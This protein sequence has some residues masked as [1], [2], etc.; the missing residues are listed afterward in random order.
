MCEQTEV[1]YLEGDVVWVKLGACWWPGRVRDVDK[2]PDDILESFRKK[3]IAAVQFF[4]EDKYEY[5]KNLDQICRYNCRRKTDFIKK[6]LDMYRAKQREGSSFMDKFPND[7]SMAEQLTGGNP[8]IVTDNAF[9]PEEK[10]S[11]R[12]IFGSEKK[13]DKKGKMGSSSP[14]KGSPSWRSKIA[15]PSTPK[16][17][18][19]SP[20][21]PITHPRIIRM[22]KGEEE[23]HDV[24]IRQQPLTPQREPSPQ[25]EPYKCYKCDFTSKRLNV[26]ILHSKSHSGD[27]ATNGQ[28]P[29]HIRSKS[30]TILSTPHRGRGRPRGSHSG[31]I[32]RTPKNSPKVVP[33]NSSDTME[34]NSPKGTSALDVN[35]EDNTVKDVVT[36][37]EKKGLKTPIFGKRKNAKASGDKGTKKKKSSEDFR[38]KLLAEWEDEDQEEEEKEM[39]ILKRELSKSEALSSPPPERSSE[40]TNYSTNKVSSSSNVKPKEIS[41]F[42]FDEQADSLLDHE[43]E[44]RAKKF[45]EARKFPRR[46]DDKV[47]LEKRNEVSADVPKLKEISPL[48]TAP[49]TES[50]DYDN[51][52]KKDL[53]TEFENLMAETELPSLPAVPTIKIKEQQREVITSPELED[54][55]NEKSETIVHDEMG[56]D[57]SLPHLKDTDDVEPPSNTT[58]QHPPETSIQFSQDST[59]EITAE[60]QTELAAEIP[61][62]TP[63]ESNDNVPIESQMEMSVDH[64]IDLLPSA[65]EEQSTT[66]SVEL[67]LQLPSEVP[68]ET[69]VTTEP[70]VDISSEFTQSTP[71]NVAET[72]SVNESHHPPPPEMPV[73][74]CIQEPAQ[75]PLIPESTQISPEQPPAQ[76]AV[77]EEQTNMTLPQETAQIS[78]MHDTTPI[79][80]S[81][82]PVQLSVGQ[83]PVQMSLDEMDLDINSMPVVMG[84]TL[85]TEDSTTK[86]AIN[87]I[88]PANSVAI[89]LPPPVV[90][91]KPTIQPVMRLTSTA[92][93]TP[94][95]SSTVTL[96]VTPTLEL[97]TEAST[98]VV[99]SSAQT[100]TA[101]S[102]PKIVKQVVK[103]VKIHPGPSG[104]LRTSD[105]SIIAPKGATTGSRYVVIQHASGKQTIYATSSAKSGQQCVTVKTGASQ[106]QGSTQTVGKKLVIVKSPQGG[107][108]SPE[109]LSSLQ[110]GKLV[111]QRIITSQGTILK[112]M[113]RSTPKVMH[114][115]PQQMKALTGG[116]QV[117][118]TKLTMQSTP[119][120]VVLPT[121]QKMVGQGQSVKLVTTA[122]SAKS[123]PNTILIQTT[124]GTSVGGAIV[125]RAVSGSVAGVTTSVAKLSTVPQT[126]MR[127]VSGSPRSKIVAT[128]SPS[129]TSV[130]RVVVSTAG[131]GSVLQG[132][133]QQRVLAARS[134]VQP[135]M[136]VQK[137][138]GTSTVRV[139]NVGAIAGVQPQVAQVQ[140]VKKVQGALPRTQVLQK[141]KQGQVVQKVVT[142][143]QPATATTIKPTSSTEAAQ[144]IALPSLQPLQ[145][146]ISGAPNVQQNLQVNTLVLSS[147]PTVINQNVSTSQSASLP[148]ATSAPLLS[149]EHIA[150]VI[151][152]TGSEQL[153]DG[154]TPTYVLVTIDDQ[155]AIQPYDSSGLVTSYDGSS[156]SS[157]SNTRTLYIDPS[158]LGTSGELDNIFL[159]I[160]NTGTA[161]SGTLL[162][163]GQANTVASGNIATTQHSQAVF[164]I[165]DSQP[166]TPAGSQDIL[167]AALANTDVFQTDGSMSDSLTVVNSSQS[168]SGSVMTSRLLESSSLLPSSTSTTL[169]QTT[170]L[171]PSLSATAMPPANPAGVLETSLTLNQPIMTPLEVPSSVTNLQQPAPPIPTSLE[172]PLTITQPVLSMPATSPYSTLPQQ[173]SLQAPETD[174]VESPIS[175]SSVSQ[176]A[177]HPVLSSRPTLQP[178]MPLLSEDVSDSQTT[179]T[180]EANTDAEILDHQP[181]SSFSTAQT[182][183]EQDSEGMAASNT[184]SSTEQLVLP[185]YAQVPEVSSHATEEHE[186]PNDALNYDTS[187]GNQQ[188]TNQDLS[189]SYHEVPESTSEVSASEAQGTPEIGETQSASEQTVSTSYARSLQ[190]SVPKERTEVIDSSNPPTNEPP[191]PNYSVENSSEALAMKDMTSAQETSHTDEVCV[192]YEQVESTSQLRDGLGEA[193]TEVTQTLPSESSTLH[194]YAPAPESTSNVSGEVLEGNS[195]GTFSLPSYSQTPE[196]TCEL[197]EEKEVIPN[198]SASGNYSQVPESTS[199]MSETRVVGDSPMD[200]LDSSQHSLDSSVLTPYQVPESSSEASVVSYE[201]AHGASGVTPPTSNQTGYTS[202]SQVPESTSQ[203]HEVLSFS[204]SSTE[205]S[206]CAV[207]LAQSMPLLLDSGPGTKRHVEGEGTDAND[208]E[209]SKRVK[210][211]ESERRKDQVCPSSCPLPTPDSLSLQKDE[212]CIASDDDDDLPTP[213]FPQPACNKKKFDRDD[214]VWMKINKLY[215]PGVV[216]RGFKKRQLAH[217]KFIN[218]PFQAAT[219]CKR[220]QD[221]IDF[222]DNSRNQQLLEEGREHDPTIEEA[223]DKIKDFWF[224]N[225]KTGGT[226]SAAK[227]FS[228]NVDDGTFESCNGLNFENNASDGN[229]MSPELDLHLD[230]S[231]S[232]KEIENGKSISSHQIDGEAKL[233]LDVIESP[234]C[235]EHLQQVFSGFTESWRHSL[236]MTKSCAKQQSLFLNSGLGPFSYKTGMKMITCLDKYFME[237]DEFNTIARYGSRK[238]YLFHVLVP[239]ALVYA[240][241]K[242]HDL[243]LE[244]AEQ[245]F[246][247]LSSEVI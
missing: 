114:V 121:V 40:G 148:V 138:R 91:E 103:S 169:H 240:I 206:D 237:I 186:A 46:L 2:L 223:F 195:S 28:E 117:G 102:A 107:P 130:Q 98:S 185:S 50:E 23:Q 211:D 157:E 220:F 30:A 115:T 76:L 212:G 144:S 101:N 88:V 13:P 61:G 204:D 145:S 1:H 90:P 7:V 178:S 41:C 242:V 15:S 36:T 54:V 120:K 247:D 94:S 122:T 112:Q 133:A 125:T 230:L 56:D 233:L 167:A 190:D 147:A 158:S 180:T 95:A 225:Y 201:D 123:K 171:L 24:R 196:S 93:S 66:Q 96:N 5:V 35:A 209:H 108:V 168:T 183:T 181:G 149:H 214:I 218:K 162:N 217:V 192:P 4:N 236:F 113:G 83:E 55:K 234:V 159:A 141:G 179:V 53:S 213:C 43:L 71:E 187:S 174:A 80:V 245:R 143:Q 106:G 156:Q 18:F 110:Q 199:H 51:E 232:P 10:P 137:G 163:L 109:V 118:G 200:I 193:V 22:L 64:P 205:V 11:Y 238:D 81:Q 208:L 17:P 226:L 131:R 202:C 31:S 32:G 74:T 124:Q 175:S 9:A 39:L 8:D 68:N 203:M 99:K 78:P 14:T 241:S 221:L 45:A 165:G 126:V 25:N 140:Q 198:Q 104:T 79:S 89:T 84:D 166:T 150:Q 224:R 105:G 216:I 37:S 12:G 152:P 65:P 19:S 85:I 48:K 239:E 38:E 182:T 73:E 219:F 188:L 86:L 29:K 210:L 227:Y 111:S 177:S 231:R 173:G 134:G 215:V 164:N 135:R 44:E 58:A 63:K 176:T 21:R 33:L 72:E 49:S 246:I 116:K 153:A 70:S 47:D 228:C 222:D 127:Q 6:G 62:D 67:P 129:G 34:T 100:T 191:V 92:S 3:P 244:E 189:T 172:L 151:A 132:Q 235:K 97:V 207:T 184:S 136:L 160:N 20:R 42:D 146:D 229:M 87:T 59:L 128:A 77:A 26:V 57:E 154:A 27:G 170:V 82:E 69:V 60:P 16:T 119:T 155:G 52:E 197:Q 75:V 139:P 194:P 243:N 142:I 161:G